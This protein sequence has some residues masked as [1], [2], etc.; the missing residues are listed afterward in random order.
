V[1]ASP[2]LAETI[3]ER[4]IRLV[5]PTRAMETIQ[6]VVDYV[7]G[8]S[9]RDLLFRGQPNSCWRIESKFARSI[10]TKSLLGK[11]GG[12][13][14]AYAELQRVLAACVP[15]EELL[16]LEREYPGID[17]HF[18]L[19]RD[20]RQYPEKPEYFGLETIAV[21][22]LLEWKKA[23]VFLC[24]EPS[25]EGC[26][27]VLDH[28]ALGSVFKPR[29]LEEVHRA[30]LDAVGDRRL[31]RRPYILHPPQ[32]PPP[33]LRIER[34]QPILMIQADVTV[35]LEDAFETLE[36]TAHAAVLSYR[37]VLVPAAMKP[38][39]RKLLAAEGI[40]FSWLMDLPTQTAGQQDTPST[41][42]DT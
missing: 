39:L 42:A 14:D 18:E 12:I 32:Q 38:Q 30:I 11:P 41:P 17:A 27:F 10:A 13:I 16:A 1:I 4:T 29:G 33:S 35:S 24:E 8:D 22:W 31:P 6:A 5:D 28:H 26:L 23:L 15:S 36:R 20:I 34:Q 3:D 25:V 19:H 37:R 2:D 7:R 21:E 9:S 40:S